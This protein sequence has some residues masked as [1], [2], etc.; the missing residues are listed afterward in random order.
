MSLDH[1]SLTASDQI[2]EPKGADSASSGQVYKADGAGSGSFQDLQEFLNQVVVESSADLPPAAAGI[3]TLVDGVSYVFGADVDIGS[4]R[5]AIESGTT[6]CISGLCLGVGGITSTTSNPLITISKANLYCRGIT[7]NCTN[8]KVVALTDAS[9]G[10][11]VWFDK[12]IFEDVDQICSFSDAGLVELLECNIDAVN[13]SPAISVTGDNR[14]LTVFR[15]D[16][17][18]FTGTLVDLNSATLDNPELIGN[19]ITV[20]STNTLISG[21][22]SG[23]NINSGGLGIIKDNISTGG[24]FTTSNINSYDDGWTFSGNSDLANSAVKGMIH[25]SGNTGAITVTATSEY[26]DIALDTSTSW[27]LAST[28]EQVSNPSSGILQVDSPNPLRGQVSVYM[29]VTAATTNQNIKAA[30]FQKLATDTT[31]TWTQIEDIEQDGFTTTSARQISVC[32]PANAN[33]G[34][35]FKVQLSN[36]TG[37]NNLIVNSIQFGMR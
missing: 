29:A 18:G 34:D 26:Y 30:I 1:A 19:I 15:C 37:T 10:H 3:H 27:S 13:S 11:S 33:E 31:G 20:D 12:C 14:V 7:F 17:S 6:V 36:E 9:K 8:G 16:I 5:L 2:H 21:L 32:A 24:T 23:A 35:Q 4:N 28:S 22:A 25:F